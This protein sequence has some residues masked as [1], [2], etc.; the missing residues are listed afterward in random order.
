VL[1]HEHRIESDRAAAR[2]RDATAPYTRFIRAETDRLNENG[3]EASELLDRT[4]RLRH[5]VENATGLST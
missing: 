1:T 5:D 4:N 3:R 2:L